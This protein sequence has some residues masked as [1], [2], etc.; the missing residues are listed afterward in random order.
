MYVSP[1]H[2]IKGIA[3]KDFEINPNN[4]VRLRKQLLADLNLSGNTTITIQKKTYTKD[5]IIKTIDVLINTTNL[6][7]HEFIFNN[8][9][10]LNFFENEDLKYSKTG[11]D[12][13][14]IPDDIKKS[15]F[16]LLEQRIIIQFKKGISKRVFKQSEEAIVLVEVLEEEQKQNCY[17][18]IHKT[19]M[20]LNSFL[21]EI[22]NSIRK[23]NL[24]EKSIRKSSITGEQFSFLG[25]PFFADMLNA[26]PT[27]FNELIIDISNTTI[28]VMYS[29]HKQVK[30]DKKLTANISHMLMKIRFL[31]KSLYDLI[32]SNHRFY[33]QFSASDK[34]FKGKGFYLI[35]V[36]IAII[37]K[38]ALCNH[39]SS[40]TKYDFDYYKPIDLSNEI[41]SL[42]K[43]KNIL[44]N[45]KLF[46][47][48]SYS[49]SG[50]MNTNHYNSFDIKTGERPFI[51]H[52]FNTLDSSNANWNK[53][54]F[55]EN[56]TSYDLILF[57]LD[58]AQEYIFT[59]Y[60]KRKENLNLG[61][62]NKSNLYFFFGKNIVEPDSTYKNLSNYHEQ[63]SI[64]HPNSLDLLG[65]EY[66]INITDIKKK[67]DKYK[68][69]LNDSILETMRDSMNFKNFNLIK[70]PEE[71]YDKGMNY[72]KK[73]YGIDDIKKNSKRRIDSINAQF[74]KQSE[75]NN[76]DFQ[77]N[78]DKINEDLKNSLNLIKEKSKR[79]QV[80]INQKLS[81][82]LE[83][84]NKK[85]KRKMDSTRYY[86]KSGSGN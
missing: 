86:E 1:L 62:T 71:T 49:L 22:D 67:K 13:L 19:L 44:K 70:K 52:K 60:I 16:D 10:L 15:L 64:I 26:L 56:N 47:S 9:E 69:I 53:N 46:T 72:T 23:N 37:L 61:F 18:E 38:I 78:L 25:N 74:K 3:E 57:Q 30:Y 21:S 32:R 2:I 81:E 84:K 41:A 54:M 58:S 43:P 59:T 82:D 7:L 39:R 75:K 8:K 34:S 17:E 76:I 63:F 66:E 29:F 48:L 14:K 68:L 20:T 27:H 79:R 42:A 24:I 83:K 65:K 35:F 5:E 40:S 12:R 85:Y 50:V 31:E 51:A 4:L 80:S 45:Y 73:N 28:N 11:F 55:I 36:V 6:A 77:K 33:S